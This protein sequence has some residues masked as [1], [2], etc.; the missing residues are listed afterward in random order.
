[1]T[2]VR[3]RFDP[4]SRRT[5]SVEIREALADSIRTG[6]LS[7][8]TQ[9]PS[10]RSLCEEFGVARTSVR[11][12]IQGLVSLGMI[13]KRGNRS[14]VTEHLPGVGLN[15]E[16]SRKRHVHELFEVRRVVEIPIARL[17]AERASEEDQSALVEIAAGFSA[18][19][20]LETFRA[21]DRAF[22]WAV[23][24][25]CGNELLAELYGKVLESLFRSDEFDTLLSAS[26]NSKVVRQIIK[27]ASR[28]HQLIAD[29][30]SR[31]DPDAVVAA[32]ETHLGQVEGHIIGR[33]V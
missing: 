17:A 3:P 4:V 20:P 22:H 6:A 2:D 9:L 32:A 26:S 28:A 19:M 11:E 8:G 16:D 29:A 18:R 30:I 7:P 13:E 27:E 5:V 21:Q 24:R 15:G 33:M 10:E 14:Y 23:A 1:M 12:A 25:A 31:R